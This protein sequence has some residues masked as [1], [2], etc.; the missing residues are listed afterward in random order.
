MKTTH[1]RGRW[2]D[3]LGPSTT[4]KAPASQAASFN[5]AE[6]AWEFV[7]NQSTSIL[8]GFQLPHGL[9][10]NTQGGLHVHARVPTADSPA[11]AVRWDVSYRAFDE[12]MAVPSFTDTSVTI[13]YANNQMNIDGLVDID[14]SA[15]PGVDS[16]TVQVK[17][18]RDHDHAEDTQSTSVYVYDV[19]VHVEALQ[20][21]SDKEFGGFTPSHEAGLKIGT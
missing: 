13:T 1:K 14:F 10:P 4:L 20:Y 9:R 2:V 3:A 7:S 8:V 16:A 15:I 11:G 19:D 17:L 21:G 18:T 12:G 5:D 6:I